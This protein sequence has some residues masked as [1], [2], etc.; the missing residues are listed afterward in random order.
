MRRKSKS[1]KTVTQ[2]PDQQIYFYTLGISFLFVCGQNFTESINKLI[3]NCRAS[4]MRT[5]KQLML[6]TVYSLI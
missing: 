2:I 6:F 1:N 3:P 5:E 4:R